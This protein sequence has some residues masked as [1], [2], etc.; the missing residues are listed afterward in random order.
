[1]N[2]TNDL[3]ATP[4]HQKISVP[5]KHVWENC[6]RRSKQNA[7]SMRLHLLHGTPQLILIEKLNLLPAPVL[8][9][10]TCDSR[11]KS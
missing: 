9:P 10:C 3:L 4:F 2:T 5:Y 7:A 6:T 8:C 11:F 1:M